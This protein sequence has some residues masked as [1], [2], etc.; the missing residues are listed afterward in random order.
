MRG[1]RLVFFSVCFGMLS[2]SY[3]ETQACSEEGGLRSGSSGGSASILFDNQSTQNINVYWLD[4]SGK[5]TLYKHLS[6]GQSHRQST[7]TGH[8]WLISDADDNCIQI[9][10]PAQNSETVRINAESFQST[11]T[12]TAA[13]LERLL[14]GLE[15]LYAQYLSPTAPTQTAG[16]WHYRHYPNTGI[17]IGTEDF[18]HIYATGGF[19]GTQLLL[20]GRLWNLLELVAGNDTQ[21]SN[22]TFSR[23][24]KQRI[25]AGLGAPEASLN[26]QQGQNIEFVWEEQSHV[27]VNG[28]RFDFKAD[29]GSAWIYI[30]GTAPSISEISIF[31]DL[32]GQAPKPGP[33]SLSIINNDNFMAPVF[34][35]YT[36]E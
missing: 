29:G 22:Q 16:T 33:M 32:S 11:I 8:P 34:V 12:A 26:F 31:K 25:N 3:A 35:T 4:F 7:F 19:L 21:S 15:P 18:D 17:Y 13:D 36:F 24:V 20:V 5:R 14:N 10:T 6:A 2:N 23:T 30:R 9:F 28:L 1:F 27:D